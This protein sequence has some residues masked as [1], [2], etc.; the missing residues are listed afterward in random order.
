[1]V[2]R[3][4]LRTPARLVGVWLPDGIEELTAAPRLRALLE[5]LR[6]GA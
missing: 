6:T 3:F 1:M 5:T 4:L 2:H